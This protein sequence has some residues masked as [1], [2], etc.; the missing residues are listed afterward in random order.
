M[1]VY[2]IGDIQGCFAELRE[3]LDVLKF[4]PAR[5]RLWFTGDL[6]N[7]GPDSLGALRFVR[8]LGDRAITVLGNHDLHLLACAWGKRK[9]HRKDTLDDV[10]RAPDRDELLDWLRRLPLLHWDPALG[11][12]LIHA[13]LPPQW[14][15]A[16][17]QALAQEVEAVLRSE[18]ITAFLEEMYGNEPDHWRKNLHGWERLRFITNCLTR[19]RYCDKKG[20]VDLSE[21]NA[22]GR[23]KKGL[24]PWFTVPER[25]S[26]EEPLIFGHWATLR[27]TGINYRAHNVHGIDT[28]CVWGGALTALCLND[29]REIQIKSRTRVAGTAE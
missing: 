7:R 5:D 8:N 29:G 12:T 10:L 4:D 6:V 21:K 19:M 25:R 16:Q 24:L 9:P 18:K 23:Q 13:G 26:A 22:P 11:Y 15:I 20:R 28:G 27:L 2:A 14:D 17:A 3:L 1:S